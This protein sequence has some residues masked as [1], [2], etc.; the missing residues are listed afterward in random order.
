MSKVGKIRVLLTMMGLDGHDRGIKLVAGALR[1]SGMEVLFTGPW[2]TPEQVVTAALQEDVQ[3]IGIS[4]LGYDHVLIPRMLK[5]LMAKGLGDVLVVVGGI[6]PPDEAELL[7]SG[8][9]AEIFPP[10][11]HL[12][13]IVDFI[14]K[15]APQ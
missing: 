5:Q 14:L 15:N 4:T 12:D 6:I 11:T 9:V 13:T 2:Q 8:G 10:G 3:V 1:D 7:K